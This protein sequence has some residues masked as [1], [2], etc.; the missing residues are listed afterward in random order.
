MIK[1]LYGKSS[2]DALM[3]GARQIAIITIKL[4]DSQEGD[5]YIEIRNSDI[6]EGS[7][8]LNRSCSSSG[9]IEFGSVSAA[10]LEFSIDDPNR[11]Y[12]NTPFIGAIIYFTLWWPTGEGTNDCLE[13]FYGTIDEA[14]KTKDRIK[15]VAIDAMVELDKQYDPV[16]YASYTTPLSLASELVS[17]SVNAFTLQKTVNWLPNEDRTIVPYPKNDVTCRQV[18]SWCCALMGACAWSSGIGTDGYKIYVSP[19]RH[20]DTSKTPASFLKSMC[21]SSNFS[22]D[23]VRI[24]GVT[25]VNGENEAIVGTSDY[26]IRI[27]NPLV[28]GSI[29]SNAA[30][31]LFSYYETTS[32]HRAFNVTT[33]PMPWLTPADI[34][35]YYD[36]YENGTVWI[37]ETDFTLNGQSRFS[38][39]ANNSVRQ[40]YST[41]TPSLTEWLITNANDIKSETTFKVKS[42]PSAISNLPVSKVGILVAET[43]GGDICLQTYKTED[44]EIYYRQWSSTDGWSLW[45]LQDF[46]VDSGTSNGFTYEL[47]ASGKAEAWGIIQT[48]INATSTSTYSG[49]W[50]VDLRK[51]ITLPRISTGYRLFDAGPVTD[52]APVYDGNHV[53]CA[54]IVTSY[55]GTITFNL[56][57]PTSFSDQNLSMH[58]HCIGHGPHPTAT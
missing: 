12:I 42:D 39:N 27:E 50:Y 51:T 52:I 43:I 57:T 47:W 2:L 25:I 3:N 18:L 24:T 1:N 32:P 23:P 30:N 15:I 40:G 8:H 48:G 16:V 54:S 22:R 7:L 9:G 4:R 17:R 10:Q 37:T 14:A 38:G 29:A 33:L 20:V 35:S 45:T 53:V 19:Y 41:L 34:F 28:S 55:S 31:V 21:F 36:G 44:G 26:M 56:I 58:V 11:T 6:V 46:V 13:L 5:Q 49:G